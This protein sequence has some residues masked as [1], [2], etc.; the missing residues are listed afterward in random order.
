[1]KRE[2]RRSMNRTENRHKNIIRRINKRRV[3]QLLSLFLISFLFIGVFAVHSKASSKADRSQKYKYYT[4]ICIEYGD[5][6]WSIADQYMDRSV[7]NRA[8]YIA[9]I[10]SINHIEDNNLIQEGKKLIIPY[11]SD[12]IK[13]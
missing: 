11:Y 12:E 6:L 10:K 4:Q 9:E 7:Y 13:E 1:M 2:T 8:S 3:I 5:S